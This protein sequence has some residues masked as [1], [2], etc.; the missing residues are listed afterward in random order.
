MLDKLEN[1]YRSQGILATHFTCRSRV[2]CSKGCK[3]TFNG[4]KSAAVS[5]GYEDGDLPRLLFVSQDR[6]PEVLDQKERLP[7]AVR[8]GME[9]VDVCGLRRNQH[10]YLTHELAWYILSQFDEKLSKQD[11][12]HYFAHTNSARC[13]QNRPNEP[14]V[15]R[16]LFRNCRQHLTGE[17]QVL[18]PDIIVTQGSWARSG[19]QPI[20][21]IR[22]PIDKFACITRFDGH[23]LFWL[24]T[25]HP[26]PRN[27]RR[28]YPQRD[29]NPETGMTGRCEGWRFY[30]QRIRQFMDRTRRGFR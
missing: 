21:D 16:I 5:T 13:C 23:P 27:R 26:S 24:H 9:N 3:D 8:D 7:Q 11:V 4:P 2:E 12:N 25:Y 6:C 30:A 10:W 29:R 22:E 28:F 15:D 18:C 19:L 20:V 17:I 1:F 14:Q